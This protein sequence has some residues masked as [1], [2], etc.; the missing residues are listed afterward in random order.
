MIE[1]F[2][3]IEGVEYERAW[4]GSIETLIDAATGLAAFIISRD[5]L[6]ASNLAAAR[7][8]DL[9]DVDA[10]RKAAESDEPKP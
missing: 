5:D 2:P 1:I 4:E 7:L 6:I 8:P 3:S 10:I 9:A